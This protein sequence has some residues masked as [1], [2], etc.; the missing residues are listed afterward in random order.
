[1]NISEEDELIINLKVLSSLQPNCKLITRDTYLNVQQKNWIPQS[2][3]RWHR[4]DSRDETLKKLDSVINRSLNS[5]L[6]NKVSS[7]LKDYL[8]SSVTGL[9][10][11]KETYSV[12]VQT[13]S[14]IDTIIDKINRTLQEEQEILGLENDEYDEEEV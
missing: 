14:R 5:Y 6:S 11:L 13:C 2:I 4:G 3:K 8:L 9:T 7:N 10:N 1:M 12:C